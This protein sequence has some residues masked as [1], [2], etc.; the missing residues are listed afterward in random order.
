ML[1]I[2]TKTNV[3]FNAYTVKGRNGYA[4][5]VTRRVGNTET[6]I[7]RNVFATRSKA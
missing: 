5:V 6:G 3:T 1:Y 4:A 7:I 2:N